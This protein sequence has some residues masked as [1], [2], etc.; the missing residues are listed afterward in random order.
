MP[1]DAGLYGICLAILALHAKPHYEHRPRPPAYKPR[2]SSVA[3]TKFIDWQY[4][5]AGLRAAYLQTGSNE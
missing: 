5:M 2:S 3:Q 4:P 1:E